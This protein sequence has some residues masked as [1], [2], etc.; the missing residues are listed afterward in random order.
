MTTI[1]DL[2]PTLQRVFTTTADRLARRTGFV[3]R[4]SKLSG[5]V[6]VQTLVFGWLATPHASLEALAQTAAAVGVSI[7]AQG[8]DKRLGEAAATFLEEMLQAV[9]HTVIAAEPVA[10]PLLERF[11]AVVLCDSSTIT[12]PAALAPWWPGCTPGTAALK[13]HV[14]YDLVSGQLTGPLLSDGRTSDR[15]TPVQTGSLPAGALR[16]ADL[17]FF[18]LDVFAQL[19]QAGVFWLSRLLSGTAVYTRA[20]ERPDVLALLQAQQST[21]V[22]LPILL[23]AQ[24]RLPARLLA[25]RLPQERAD[26]RRYRLRQRAREKGETPSATSLAWADWFILVTTVPPERLSLREALVLL[27]ARWQIEELFKLW[28]NQ[29]QVDTS[30]SAKPWRILCEVY[31]KLL[32]MVVQHWLLLTGCWHLPDRSLTKAA[33][34]IRAHALHLACTLANVARLSE[35]IGIIHHCLASGCRLS[36]RKQTLSS[37]Q[38]LLDPRLGGLG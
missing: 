32:A 2:A 1:A 6:F 27:R 3:Q 10:I 28:K 7:S 23:G 29:G 33:Q 8:L 9:V 11:S 5:A 15:R 26:Q 30:V 31:A 4:A 35:T 24:H 18:T 37:F 21:I 14:R 38:L 17:G 36:R 16:L 34:T 13:L 12:L 19:S 25:V 22:D 20:G